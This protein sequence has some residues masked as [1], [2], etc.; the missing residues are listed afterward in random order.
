MT[1]SAFDPLIEQVNNT[2]GVMASATVFVLG[3]TARVDAAV[4]AALAGGATAQ[5]IA[6]LVTAENATLKDKTDALAAALVANP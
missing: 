4:A 6:D 5:E 2:V 3:Y 1:T